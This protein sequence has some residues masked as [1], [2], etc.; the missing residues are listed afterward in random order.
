MLLAVNEKK[1]DS[2][3]QQHFQDKPL[4]LARLERIRTEG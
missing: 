2:P 3:V 4:L 1:I